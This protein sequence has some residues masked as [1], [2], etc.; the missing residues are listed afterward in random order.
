MKLFKLQ[1]LTAK[2][3]SIKMKEH[4]TF[5]TLYL[6]LSEIVIS[7]FNLGEKILDYN[8][9]RKILRSLPMRFLNPRLLLQTSTL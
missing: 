4:E 9:V 8:I 2:F 1:M 7:S 6:K 3:E 5:T